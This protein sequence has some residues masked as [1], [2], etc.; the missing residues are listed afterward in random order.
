MRRPLLMLPVLSLAA[1]AAPA[2]DLASEVPKAV[3]DTVPLSADVYQIRVLDGPIT[4]RLRDY[5]QLRA[6]EL[7]LSRGFSGY[8][9]LDAASG[10]AEPEANTS[11]PTEAPPG[12]GLA[13]R[14]HLLR[15]GGIDARAVNRRLAPA[16]NVAPLAASDTLAP[17]AAWRQFERE[18]KL[19]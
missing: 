15:V 10:T 13:V 11:L 1:C 7:A 6:S 18:G 19:P 4:P 17:P 2:R 16:F 9:I 3:I 14:I 5:I 12:P 8:E